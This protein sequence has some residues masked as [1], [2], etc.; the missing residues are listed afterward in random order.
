MANYHEAK[1]FIIETDPKTNNRTPSIHSCTH[2]SEE[3][4]GVWWL[5]FIERAPPEKER[6]EG[7]KTVDPI[8]WVLAWNEPLWIARPAR[9]F[10]STR[11]VSSRS[12]WLEVNSP[13]TE[14]GVYTRCGMFDPSGQRSWCLTRWERR[15][16][17]KTTAENHHGAMSARCSSVHSSVRPTVSSRWEET[18]VREEVQLNALGWRR[19]RRDQGLQVPGT[20]CQW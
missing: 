14:R 20:H 16:S 6:V 12:S 17:R 15:N 2:P 13:L 9:K 3:E 8:T 19:Q 5:W 11:I 10:Y 7:C 1:K 4:G 18:S